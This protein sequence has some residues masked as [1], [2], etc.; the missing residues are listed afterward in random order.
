MND[1]NR[2]SQETFE[3]LKEAVRITTDIV[4]ENQENGK[5]LL[6]MLKEIKRLLNQLED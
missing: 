1:N 4:E 5:V 2:D 6:D 3:R